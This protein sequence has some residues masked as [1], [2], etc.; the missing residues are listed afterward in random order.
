MSFAG[1]VKIGFVMLQHVQGTLAY[2]TQCESQ[3]P[4][5]PGQLRLWDGR[6]IAKWLRRKR[7]EYGRLQRRLRKSDTAT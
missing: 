7:N 4:L 2:N 1:S 3:T 5:G 6:E